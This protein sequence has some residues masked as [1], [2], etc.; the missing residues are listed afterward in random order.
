MSPFLDFRIKLG[1]DGQPAVVADVSLDESAPA[2]SIAW[3]I[4]P[5]VPVHITPLGAMQAHNAKLTKFVPL[6]NCPHEHVYAMVTGMFCGSCH[7]IISARNDF[8]RS[9]IERFAPRKSGY[10]NHK[11]Q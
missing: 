9:L 7:L 10:V 11:G 6:A 1:P 8:E 3:D 2:V 5:P 4:L